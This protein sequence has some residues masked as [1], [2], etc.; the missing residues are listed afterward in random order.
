VRRAHRISVTDDGRAVE[1]AGRPAAWREAAERVADELVVNIGRHGV[2]ELPVVRAG[3]GE[4]AIVQR[5][6]A[7]SLALYQE[8]LELQG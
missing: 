8:L 1:K 4:N 6:G 7:A 2:I 5:I 3:P